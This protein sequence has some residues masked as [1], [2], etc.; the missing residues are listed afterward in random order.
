MRYGVYVMETRSGKLGD[1]SV[2]FSFLNSVTN[3][4]THECGVEQ[5]CQLSGRE[6]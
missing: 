1:H 5:R 2:D 4:R 3:M 6:L